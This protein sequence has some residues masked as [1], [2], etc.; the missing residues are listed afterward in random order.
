VIDADEAKEI[1]NLMLPAHVM[2][3]AEDAIPDAIL[4]G[5]EALRGE[6]LIWTVPKGSSTAFVLG[7]H[8]VHRLRGRWTVMSAD[9]SHPE[10]SQALSECDYRVLPIAS[11]ASFSFSVLRVE[12][13]GKKV[14]RRWQFQLNS[15]DELVLE[16]STKDSTTSHDAIK[17]ANALIAAIGE[18]RFEGGNSAHMKVA[19]P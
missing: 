8:A 17:F 9:Q 5:L 3:P 2:K 15:K 7:S 11:D 14:D 1:R 12:G 4:E 19:R 13:P 16:H 6:P 10:T 18:Q